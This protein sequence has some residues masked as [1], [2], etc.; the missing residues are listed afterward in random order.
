MAGPIPEDG[1]GFGVQLEGLLSY[2][3]TQA[4]SIGV[5]GRYWH[6]E[7]KGSSHFEDATPTGG[8]QPVNFKTDRYGAFVQGAFKF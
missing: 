5:G 4:F 1:K 8:P 3:V 7:T 2:K 6:L